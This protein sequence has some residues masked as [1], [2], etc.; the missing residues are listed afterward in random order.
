MCLI[1]L[2]TAV[3]SSTVSA[4]IPVQSEQCKTAT[5]ACEEDTDCV[6]RLAVLQ[7]TWLVFFSIFHFAWFLYS[8]ANYCSKKN[9]CLKNL[10]QRMCVFTNVFQTP[11]MFFYKILA[12][13]IIITQFSGDSLNYPKLRLN[14]DCSL[15]LK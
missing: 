15:F 12:N 5:S 4:E 1:F 7:S 10:E 2:L 13:S 9:L 11:P 8:H 6:H 14:L 3:L